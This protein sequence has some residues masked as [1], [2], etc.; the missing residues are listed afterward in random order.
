[1]REDAG[2]LDT[3]ELFCSKEVSEFFCSLEMNGGDRFREETIRQRVTLALPNADREFPEA[4]FKLLTVLSDKLAEEVLQRSIRNALDAQ[5]TKVTL[6]NL[7]R[8]FP[9]LMLDF[10]L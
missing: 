6:D 3:C 5:S 4:V 7:Y 10:S 9:H 2:V 8:I 1:M